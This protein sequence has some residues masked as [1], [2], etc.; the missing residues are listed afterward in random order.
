MHYPKLH[1]AVYTQ[2]IT[3]MHKRWY[4]IMCLCWRVVWLK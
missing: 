2:I 1:T 3:L 4:Y